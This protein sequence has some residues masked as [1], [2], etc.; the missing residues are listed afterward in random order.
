MLINVIHVSFKRGRRKLSGG[1]ECLRQPN[2]HEWASSS[3]DLP[4]EG[5]RVFE[6]VRLTVPPPL[7]PFL[8]KLQRF[9]PLTEREAQAL[10]EAAGEVRRVDAADDVVREGSQPDACHVLLDGFIA[11]H[12]SLAADKRQIIAFGIPGDTCDLDAFVGGRMDHSVVAL[13]PSTL[14]VIPHDALLAVTAAHPRL[15]RALWRETV[16]DASIFAEWVANIGRRS[17]PV[18][19]AHL[20]CE[21]FTRLQ[22]AGLAR[23]RGF[24]WPVTQKQL[25]DATGLTPVHINRV[26][27]DL[28]KDG[29]LT[30]HGSSVRIDDWEGLKR[31]SGFDPSYLNPRRDHLERA[32]RKP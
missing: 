9:A 24:E 3:T 29:L 8:H 21:T 27:R 4:Y 31:L 18:R 7:Q 19:V 2:P 14:A 1:L 11:H 5:C 17:A 23:A 10:F 26:L 30:I 16:L 28:R 12:K 22:Q 6:N 20:V 32:T 15:A 25:G 13:M